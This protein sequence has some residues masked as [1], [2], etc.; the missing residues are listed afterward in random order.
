VVYVAPAFHSAQQMTTYFTGAQ[1]FDRSRK[2]PVQSIGALDD[3]LHYVTYAGVA[4]QPQCFSEPVPLK[5]AV[6]VGVSGSDE[7]GL[8]MERES[9]VVAGLDVQDPLDAVR[10]DSIAESMLE[11]GARGL[12]QRARGDIAESTSGM[13]SFG[14]ARTIGRLLFDGE[15]T[16]VPVGIQNTKPDL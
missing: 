4:D 2:I 1:I 12:S 14:R 11:I 8:A 6:F 7:L 5:E 10:F 9:A 3:D 13:S 15:L 16:P